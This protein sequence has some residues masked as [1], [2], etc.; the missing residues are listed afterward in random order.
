M[1]DQHICL[2]AAFVMV[3]SSYFCGL[4]L[5]QYMEQCEDDWD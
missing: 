5:K 2:I 4:F 3:A 1:T